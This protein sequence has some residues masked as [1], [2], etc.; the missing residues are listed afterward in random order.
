MTSD[1]RDQLLADLSADGDYGVLLVAQMGGV[2]NELQFI[3]E[4]ARYD[5][6]VQGLRTRG[7]YIVRALGVRE[8]QVHVGVFGRLAFTQDHPL[9]LHHNT[10]RCA[11]HFTGRAANPDA[12][13]LDIF[14][15]Y[16]GVFGPWRNLAAMPD[17]LNPS[18]PLADLLAGGFGLLGVLPKPVAQ[19]M[20]TVLTRH[21]LGVS[22]SEQ[23]DFDTSDEHGRSKLATLLRID[24]G[25][26]IALDFSVEH[27]SRKAQ[28]PV[29]P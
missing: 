10:P 2:P 20:E 16:L 24:A 5:E 13:M 26:V 18:Q 1:A 19:R 6:A 12:L 21:G 7:G 4:T 25:Y 23:P 22:L 9:L 14:Q 15:V 8:H 17:D 3:I 29:E 28:P 27:M 11:V